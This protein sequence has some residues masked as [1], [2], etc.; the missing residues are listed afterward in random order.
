MWVFILKLFSKVL[1][2]RTKGMDQ[3]KKIDM[4]HIKK[5]ITKRLKT[6][7]TS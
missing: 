7:E 3:L 1:Q 5:K 6:I 2:I 4:A